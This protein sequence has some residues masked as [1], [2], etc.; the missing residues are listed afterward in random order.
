MTLSG[1]DLPD[2]A[3]LTGAPGRSVLKL[4]GLGPLLTARMARKITLENLILDGAGG[5][6]PKDAGLVD[7]SDVVEFEVRGCTIRNARGRGLNLTRCGGVV[8]QTTIENVAEAGIF[9]LDGLG[10][11]FASNEI[12]R[13][14]DNGLVLWSSLAGRF[15]GARVEANLIEDVSARSGGNGPYGNGV[16]IFGAGSVRVSG[17]RILRCAYSAVRNNAGHGVEV[18]GNDCKGFGEKAMYAEFGAKN[19]IFRDNRIEDAGAGIA[20]ANADKG[21]DG[22]LILGNVVRAM[23]ASHPDADFGPEMLWRT[24]ILAEKNADIRGNRIIG[25]GWIGVALGGWRENLRAEENDISGVDYGVVLATG[26]GVGEA[27][28][29]RNRIL[30]SKGAV[31]AAAGMN[32][33]P[34]DLTKPGAAFYPRLTVR[35]NQTG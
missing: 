25:P 9:A 21:T 19:A 31:V 14:G 2:G 16:L 35:D 17:N 28:V 7:A 24:G 23:K 5:I 30:A 20:V 34:G 18:V 27:L 8:T 10:A 15:D 1:L 29:A 22:A 6:F 3:V 11:R 12:R 13:C 33:L 26:D 4:E 32:F